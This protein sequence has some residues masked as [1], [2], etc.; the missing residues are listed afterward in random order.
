MDGG[1]HRSVDSRSTARASHPRVRAGAGWSHGRRD[2]DPRTHED[3]RGPHGGRRHRPRRPHAARCF[4]LLGPNGA[5]KT[6]TVEIVEGYR[7]PRRRR[8]ARARHRPVRRRPRLAQPGRH[9]AAEHRRASTSSPSREARRHFAAS[10]GTRATPPRCSTS[11]GPRRQGRRPHR[12]GCPVASAGASTWRWASSA[13]PSCSSSTSRRPASTPRPAAT[14]GTSSATSRPSGT[15]ILLTT[16]YLDEAE[17]L[18]DRVGV[19]A[20][21]RLR[22]RR[23]PR[24]AGR[25]AAEPRRRSAGWRAASGTAC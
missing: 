5:G 2:H 6:T 21:G 3:L 4:A 17:A 12:G 24:G 7:A 9:R 19:I 20:A 23:H 1:V 11:V 14:S 15:T 22:R 25:R 13:G 18:A 10:T 16:H 8:G